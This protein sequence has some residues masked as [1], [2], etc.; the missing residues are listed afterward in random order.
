MAMTC[1]FRSSLGEACFLEAKYRYSGDGFG[2]P[3]LNRCARHTPPSY[4]KSRYSIEFPG[5]PSDPAHYVHGMQNANWPEQVTPKRLQEALREDYRLDLP[6]GK[7]SSMLRKYALRPS[8]PAQR[9][10]GAVKARL[11]R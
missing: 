3:K 7:C 1:D 5:G 4:R 11:T 8:F 2:S 6:I 10:R 9:K